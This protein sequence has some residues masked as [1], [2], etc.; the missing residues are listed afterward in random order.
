[1]SLSHHSASHDSHKESSHAQS[2]DHS[3]GDP[4]EH[5]TKKNVT[6]KT[7]RFLVLFVLISLGIGL[8]TT[9]SIALV[10]LSETEKFL[11]ID[12]FEGSSIKKT[13]AKISLI[14]DY[15][16]KEKAIFKGFPFKEDIN[17]KFSPT[18]IVQHK[19]NTFD[20]NLA[21]FWK[22]T[23][24]IS[25]LDDIYPEKIIF[26]FQ[27]ENSTDRSYQRMNFWNQDGQKYSS[28]IN[29]HVGHIISHY[30]GNDQI[31][32]SDLKQIDIEKVITNASNTSQKI[33]QIAHLLLEFNPDNKNYDV[34]FITQNKQINRF[35]MNERGLILQK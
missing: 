29:E 18:V 11:Y 27:K 22:T 15:M 9:Y 2:S 7:Q 8:I 6:S 23:K 19:N 14:N 32:P 24:E 17:Q 31:M 5:K 28:E 21:S 33:N 13:F 25:Q 35:F 30:T 16:W 1:M 4:H 20:K 12:G 10:K 3:A 26:S 34:T